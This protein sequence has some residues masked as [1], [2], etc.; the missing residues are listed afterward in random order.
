MA[1]GTRKAKQKGCLGVHLHLCPTKHLICGVVQF[2][3]AKNPI[4]FLRRAVA[5]AAVQAPLPQPLSQGLRWGPPAQ[6]SHTFTHAHTHIH[7]ACCDQEILKQSHLSLLFSSG[8]CEKK[9]GPLILL[10]LPVPLT[11]LQ[12][13]VDCAHHE[14]AERAKKAESCYSA[15]ML[16]FQLWAYGGKGESGR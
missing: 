12:S 2:S 15:E 1:I 11:P 5:K 16:M 14:C 4:G 7:I 6:P 13:N 9:A 8:V 10:N 3:E